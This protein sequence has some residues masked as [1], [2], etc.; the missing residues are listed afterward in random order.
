MYINRYLFY[1]HDIKLTVLQNTVE[2][3]L[4]LIVCGFYVLRLFILL[5]IL[6]KLAVM[7]W[8]VNIKRKCNVI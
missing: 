7:W 6:C 3:E 4:V 8:K 1:K 5:Y 2:D